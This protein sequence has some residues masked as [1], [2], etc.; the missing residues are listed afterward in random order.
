MLSMGKFEAATYHRQPMQG[1]E[2]EGKV[3]DHLEEAL[4]AAK[5][6]TTEEHDGNVHRQSQNRCQAGKGLCSLH[7]SSLVVRRP[8]NFFVLVNEGI[9][10]D[11]QG[12]GVICEPSRQSGKD[13]R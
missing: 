8:V 6:D 9:V 12:T 3:H 4:F 2:R 11:D 10:H 7:D 13:G 5:T 1:C